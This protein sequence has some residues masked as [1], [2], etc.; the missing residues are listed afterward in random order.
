MW[1]VLALLKRSACAPHASVLCL[2]A[3]TIITLA[4]PE[5]AWAASKGHRLLQRH[6]LQVQGMVT[7]DDV[8]HLDTYRD[9]HYSTVNWLWESDFNQLGGQAFPWARWVGD[10]TQMPTSNATEAGKLG[11]L[12]ALQLGDEW[13]LNDDAVRNRAVNWFNA[14]RAQ[15]PDTLLYMNSFGGQVNDAALGD[16][17][18]RAKPDL[19]MFD[20]YPYRSQYVANPPPGGSKIGAPIGGPPTSWYGDLRRYRVHALNAKIP[21]GAYRQTFHAVQDYDAT[22]YRDPSPSEQNL[23]TFGALAFG[24]TYLIDFTYNTGAS[25]LFTTPGGDSNPTPALARQAENNR[26]A[27]TLGHS[28][29]RLVPLHDAPNGG[30]PT[31]DILF[32]RGHTGPNATDRT[33]VPVGFAADDFSPNA[34]TEW[35]AGAN[36]P[37]MAG[38]VVNN[39]GTRNEGRRGDAVI[40]WFKPLDPAQDDPADADDQLYFM[41]ANGLTGPE[42]SADEYR[43]QIIINFLAAV[44]RAAGD[45]APSLL[46]LDQ[47]T[48]EVEK[49]F[50]EPIPNSTRWRL[51]VTLDGGMSELYKFNTGAFIVPEPASLSLFAFTGLLFRR[52]RGNRG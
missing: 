18:A 26:R 32:I 48:G 35:S 40:S 10:E 49:V 19:L 22:V 29:T 38:F 6:G 17:I 27:R 36:D 28:L 23:N 16:F 12:V 50:L 15:Y 46:R 13:H 44:P 11:S 41:V 20:T 43:Q 5:G 24:A 30:L 34:M 1:G 14:V 25:S 39:L 37:W 21:F 3:M 42:G 4:R 51:N 52:P 8:F 7:K 9:A 2:V 33:P 47:L 31:T 45:T